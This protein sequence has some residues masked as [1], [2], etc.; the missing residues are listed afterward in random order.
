MPSI[1]PYFPGLPP[2]IRA[3]NLND[4]SAGQRSPLP[5]PMVPPPQSVALPP[6]QQP[7][8]QP[9]PMPSAQDQ[10]PIAGNWITSAGSWTFTK[11]ADGYHI[12]EMS[13][14]GQSG[15]GHATLRGGVLFVNFTGMLGYVELTLT[16]EGNML[17]GTMPFLGAGLP[18]VFRR[19]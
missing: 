16:L 14:L 9:L 11:T 8:P 2:D 5:G 1:P 13:A 4:W 18:I 15:Q 17:S 3:K 19:V 7:V 6:V 12:V 10:D